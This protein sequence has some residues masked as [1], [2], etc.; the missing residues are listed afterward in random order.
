VATDTTKIADMLKWP[1]PSSVTELRGFLGLTGYYRKFVSNYGLLAKS[2]TN[3]LKLKQFQW[4]A[5]AQLTFDKLKTAMTNTPVLALLDFKIQ[6]IV[7]TD[8]CVKGIGVVLMQKGQ[9]VAYLSKALLVLDIRI[10]QSMKRNSLLSLW[11]WRSGEPIYN[12][13]SLF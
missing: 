13:N 12:R 4:S 8:A 3:I 1:T 7:E 5:A 10:Y 2:L 9:P 11:L 6:F